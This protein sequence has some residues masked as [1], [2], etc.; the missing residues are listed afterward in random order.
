MYL[1]DKLSS[2]AQKKAQIIAQEKYEM[3]KCN[4]I[5]TAMDVGKDL[6]K[7]E[8]LAEGEHNAKVETAK[9]VN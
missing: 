3:D 8:C 4:E 6:G 1:Y 2:L 7:E 5:A 9:N